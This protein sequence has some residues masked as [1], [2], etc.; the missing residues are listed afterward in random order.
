M[1]AIIVYSC[2]IFIFRR[3]SSF[4]G[5]IVCKC[6]KSSV[7]VR[8]LCSAMLYISFVTLV[9]YTNVY[10]PLPIPLSCGPSGPQLTGGDA[11]APPAAPPQWEGGGTT[12]SIIE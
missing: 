11:A 5:C 8:V 7:K 4:L 2:S 6:N 9:V 12:L 10:L 1:C 3:L